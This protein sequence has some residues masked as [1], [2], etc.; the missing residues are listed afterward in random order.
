MAA[1]TE[2]GVVEVEG[3]ISTTFSCYTYVISQTLFGLNLKKDYLAT[4]YYT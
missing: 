1:M 2:I 3:E 4:N